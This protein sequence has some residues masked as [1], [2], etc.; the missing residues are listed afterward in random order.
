MRAEKKSLQQLH[1]P[2]QESSEQ[3][4]LQAPK[5]CL[6]KIGD[7]IEKTLT[8][9]FQHDQQLAENW[10]RFVIWLS[11]FYTNILPP[12]LVREV[13]LKITFDSILM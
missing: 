2:D 11:I 10:R 7:H 9:E 3:A 6:L 4:Q 1:Q 13:L 5:K 12:E 8:T